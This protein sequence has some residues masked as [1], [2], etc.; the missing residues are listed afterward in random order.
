MTKE[1]SETS[2]GFTDSLAIAR[3]S[4]SADGPDYRRNER[5]FEEINISTEPE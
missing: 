1:V 4:V 3:E 2:R 5:G